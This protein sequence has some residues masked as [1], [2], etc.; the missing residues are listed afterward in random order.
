MSRSTTAV[1]LFALPL[2]LALPA[3]FSETSTELAFI[4]VEPQVVEASCGP[5]QFDLPGEGCL[6]AVRIDG[7]AMFVDGTGIDDHGDSHADDG[8]CKSIR[9]ARVVG[10]EVDGRFQVHEMELI[11]ADG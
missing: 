2:A 1:L 4:D 7:K 5:C 8:F 9:Q 11:S 3:C 6:L 10:A